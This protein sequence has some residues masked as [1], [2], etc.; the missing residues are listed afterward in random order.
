[1]SVLVLLAHLWRR[2]GL[3][4]VWL[5][6]ANGLF[7]WAITRVVPDPSQTGFVRQ[8]LQMAP[9]PVRVFVNQ[10]IFA[11]LTT[12]GFLGFGY[13]HPFLLLLLAVWAV[14]VA[15]DALAGEVGRGTIDLIG[16]RPVARASQVTAAAI[17]LLAGLTLIAG[18]AW[19]GTAVGLR[20]RPLEGVTAVDLAPVAA[21]ALLLFAVFAAIALLVSAAKRES[22]AAVSWCAAIVAGSYVVDYLA[23]VWSTIGFLRPLSLFRYYEPQRIL[24]EGG[25]ATMD[26][27]VLATVGVVALVTAFA[28]F[29]RRDL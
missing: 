28:V 5:A 20:S 24:R 10:E 11:N 4:L 12:Q 21:M 26:V 25:I 7:E 15:A 14:R 6:T 2:H 3:A 1:M 27:A 19:V 29:A 16:S 9:A 18:G 8:I 17:A 22:G 13:V 23:R